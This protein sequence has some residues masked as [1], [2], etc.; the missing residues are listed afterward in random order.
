[1]FR[2]AALTA[3]CVAGPTP[4]RTPPPASTDSALTL[5]DEQLCADP[6]A[7]LDRFVDETDARGLGVE[8]GEEG[9]VLSGGNRAGTLVAEDMD[10]DGDIDLVLPSNFWRP[11][12]F[13][14]DGSGYF[15]EEP[16][17]PG[18]PSVLA[19][20]AADLDGDGLPELVQCG[21]GRVV[22]WTNLGGLAFSEPETVLE[23]PLPYP[24]CATIAAGDIDLDGDIDLAMPASG[25]VEDA[26][27]LDGSCPSSGI[28]GPVTVLVNDGGAYH[29]GATLR[30][31]EV[32]GWSLAATMTDHD[33][34][35]DLDLFVLSDRSNSGLAPEDVPPNAL[36]RNDGPGPDGEIVW[37]DEAEAR[38]LAIP[39]SGMGFA[40]GDYNEDGRLDYCA[41]DAGPVRCFYSWDEIYYD[42]GLALGLTPSVSDPA[43]WFGWSV[44]I[45]DL[46]YDGLL[47]A[48]VSAGRPSSDATSALQPDL[49]F[50]GTPE[51]FEDISAATGFGSDGDDFGAAAADLD[52]DGY[53]E[54]VILPALGRPQLYA[55]H[56][57]A[58]AWLAVD[59][60]GPPGN[61]AGLG[62][63]IEVDVGDR[64]YTQEIQGL[65]SLGQSPSMAWFGL[66]DAVHADRLAVVW[67]GGDRQEFLDVPA[68]RRVTVRA[69]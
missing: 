47:D 26:C 6:V 64:R 49:L 46:D 68:R 44:E 1:M 56:C 12:I 19:H 30:F 34:D 32:D 36:Y 23:L 33:A 37:V 18:V 8:L 20:L 65:R 67:P 16:P 41:S 55:N 66:G 50:Q 31:G 58:E 5:G 25:A 69:E 7:G 57:G 38:E 61:R 48:F 15:T 63:R 59:L 3:A 10:A 40:T 13:G 17:V 27:E 21:V 24:L 11:R 29:V 45:V 9:P 60:V 62:A 52:G 14:N 54:M 35:G 53:L 4:H 2:A 22:V 42:A 43:V 28:G 39:M 51:G